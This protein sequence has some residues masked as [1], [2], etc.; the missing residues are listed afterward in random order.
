MARKDKGSWT[1]ARGSSRG[2]G[3]HSS[4][5]GYALRRVVAAL[6]VVAVL[7]VVVGVVQLLRPVPAP[8]F[9]SSLNVPALVPGQAPSLPWPSQGS[10]TL[11]IQ[12]VGSFGSHG[13]KSPIAI[14]SVAKM[15]TALL[16]VQDHPLSL[17][18]NGPSITITQSD[19][20][21]YLQMQAA[22][23]SVMA[24]APG[25]TLSEYQMLEGLL[26]PSAD[27]LAV[28]L[29]Q[30][31]AGSVSAFVGKMNAFA[32]KLGLTGT[33]YTDPSGLTPTT[34]ST[35][36][37]QLKIAEL[38]EQNPVL[39]QI[40]AE[41]QATLPVAGTVYNVDYDLGHDGIVGVKTGST[42]NGGDFAFAADVNVA[43]GATDKIVGVVLGQQGLQP[44][45][46]AL[47]AA[48]SLVK[49]AASVPKT[50]QV[51]KAGGVVGSITVPGK[52]SI[53]VLAKDTLTVQ[54]WA[55]LTESDSFSIK[56]KKA[57]IKEGQVV[58][59]LTMM[60]GEQH[61]STPLIAGAAIGS[62]P[63]SYRLLHL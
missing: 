38:V 46:T 6:I 21:T 32:K 28:T 55:G 2:Y 42:P 7:I 30:W 25:E 41:P 12:G 20:Q 33:T 57:P 37:D 26:I 18:Q 4:R 10:A 3:S 45:I 9:T 22:V 31:D 17:G 24:V 60:V 56:V 5:G 58:G 43:G 47:D 14:A 48:K 39:A 50:V 59:T 54:E 62:T 34:V 27:N 11:D 8:N 16:I 36:K 19:Y 13:S 52:G 40:V 15:T 35:P 23:D 29:A 63:I 1:A 61:L 53:P 49:A 51:V 44:L